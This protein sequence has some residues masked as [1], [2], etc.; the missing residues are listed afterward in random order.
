MTEKRRKFLTARLMIAVL[1]LSLFSG[2]G[3]V[4]WCIDEGD[5]HVAA[6]DHDVLYDCHSAPISSQDFHPSVVELEEYRGKACLDVVLA[7][8]TYTTPRS[9]DG[10]EVSQA[11][12]PPISMSFDVKPRGFFS[13]SR[14]QLDHSFQ[15]APQRSLRTVVIL[16]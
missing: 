3:N 8:A 11:P 15:A 4:G 10:Y 13:F 12:I 7:I 16:S 5:T 1:S 6:N 14:H 9:K 2:G